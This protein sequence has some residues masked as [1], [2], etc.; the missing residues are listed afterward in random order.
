MLAW[1]SHHKTSEVKSGAENFTN[2]EALVLFMKVF[3]DLGYTFDQAA[4]VI[5]K[6]HAAGVFFRMVST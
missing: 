2:N 4:E 3:L 1:Y 5:W 6:S